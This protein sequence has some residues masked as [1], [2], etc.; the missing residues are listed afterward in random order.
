MKK[1]EQNLFSSTIYLHKLYM[2]FY[3]TVSYYV[4]LISAHVDK[5]IDRE[6]LKQTISYN[7]H[8]ILNKY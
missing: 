3:S 1:T 2:Y 4:I 8:D 6:R 5:H 7:C